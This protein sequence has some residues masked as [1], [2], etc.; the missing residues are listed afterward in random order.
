MYPERRGDNYILLSVL[1]NVSWKKGDNYILLSL[2]VNVSDTD[3][4]M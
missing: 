4:R 3:N 1:V 2:S